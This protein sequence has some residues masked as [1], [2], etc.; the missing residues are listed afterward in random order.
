MNKKMTIRQRMYIPYFVP[1]DVPCNEP[2]PAWEVRW[3]QEGEGDDLL[4]AVCSSRTRNSVWSA[5]RAVTTRKMI[6]LTFRRVL[7][8]F[9]SFG[10]ELER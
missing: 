8:S 10:F 1:N 4:S 6:T 2:R 9:M 3:D 5:S 7:A